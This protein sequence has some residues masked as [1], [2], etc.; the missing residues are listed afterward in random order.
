MAR[1]SKPKPIAVKKPA[2]PER[3]RRMRKVALNAAGCVLFIGICVGGFFGIRH[4]VEQRVLYTDRVPTVVLVN[5]PPWMSDHLAGRIATSVQPRVPSS[6]LNRQVLVDMARILEA[7]P[8]IR[9]VRQIRRTY[10]QGPGDTI[11]VDCEYHIP[12]ALVK[13]GELYYLVDNNGVLLPESYTQSQVPLVVRGPNRQ[14]NIRI[15]TGVRGPMPRS[16]GQRWG[17]DD[18]IAGLELARCLYGQPFAEEIE[19][20]DVSNYQERVDRYAAQLVLVTRHG[21][22]V[23]WGRPIHA[24]DFFVEVG[25][26]RKLERMRLLYEQYGRVDGGFPWVDLRFDRVLNPTPEH[27]AQASSRY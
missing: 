14:V 10:R 5:R 9:Q 8:W 23:R 3:R 12:I 16:A 20:I 6:A 26:E 7:D 11:E 21:T 18:L 22:E 19:I 1:S 15:I 4:Y 2:D 25:P 17:G 27:P 13:V 24:K